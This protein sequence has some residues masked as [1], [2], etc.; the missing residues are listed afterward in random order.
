MLVSP[1]ETIDLKKGNK[2][3]VISCLAFP[4]NETNNCWCG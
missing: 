2:D 1:Q 3:L 4:Q